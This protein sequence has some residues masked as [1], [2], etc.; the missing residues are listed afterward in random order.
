MLGATF[1]MVITLSAHSGGILARQDAGVYKSFDACEADVNRV[2]SSLEHGDEYVQV[3]CIEQ[4]HDPKVN[5]IIEWH[6]NHDPV[7]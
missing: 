1:L 6:R 5:P 2:V 7:L 4:R 3:H